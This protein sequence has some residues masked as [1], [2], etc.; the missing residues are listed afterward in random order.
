[1]SI[2]DNQIPHAIGEPQG[3]Q[4]GDGGE[5]F[6]DVFWESEGEEVP[7]GTLVEEAS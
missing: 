3:L 5:S 2:V 6:T 4:G 1:M 7:E